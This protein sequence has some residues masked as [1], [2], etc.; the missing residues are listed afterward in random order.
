[1]K[2][3]LFVAAAVVTLAGSMFADTVVCPGCIGGTSSAFPVN[4]SSL[5]APFTTLNP[6]P[7]APVFWNNP[8]DDTGLGPSQGSSHMMNIG[9]VL[10]DTGGMTGA[11]SVLGSD[12][13]VSDFVATGGA[14]PAAFA[15]VRNATAYNVVLLFA[16]SGED[17]GSNPYAGAQGSQI[18]TYAGSTMTPLYNV[19]LTFSPTGSQVFNPGPLGTQYGF[20]ETVCYSS[21]AGVCT[22]FE[23]YTSGNGNYGT[24]TGGA[25]WNHFAVFQLA[26]GSYVIG[27]TGQNG[28]YGENIGDFQDT[29]IELQVA[30]AL[31]APEPGTIAMMGLGLA[32]LGFVGRRRFARK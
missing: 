25:A 32:A 29:V 7:A 21:S 18:G 10:T 27:F 30:S 13:P 20:Y 24:S 1:M 15:F 22:S 6:G 8:S 19:G 17:T 16:D 9:Y 11:T 4:F 28:L 31:S 23:T 26:S 12:T 2:R 5:T 14:D 3:L